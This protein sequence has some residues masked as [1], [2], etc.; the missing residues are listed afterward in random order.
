MMLNRLQVARTS[1]AAAEVSPVVSHASQSRTLISV[2][3]ETMEMGDL[4][5]RPLADRWRLGWIA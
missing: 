2:H 3:T 5:H 1:S 4:D